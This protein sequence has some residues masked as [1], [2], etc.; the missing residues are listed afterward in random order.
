MGGAKNIGAVGNISTGN[1]EID[2]KLGGGIPGGSLTL[3]EGQPDSGKSVLCQQILWGSLSSGHKATILT[4]ENTV[5]SLVKQMNSLNLD[6]SDY[7]LL[8]RLR[9]SPVKAIKAGDDPLAALDNLR[10]A[11]RCE[12]DLVIVDSLTSFLSRTSTEEAIAFFEECKTLSN[13]TRT[14]IGAVHSYAF[15]ESVLVRISSMCDAHLR[16]RLETMGT[17]LI[18]LLEVAKV[19]G[20]ERSTGNIISFEVEPKWGMRIIPYSKAR[21]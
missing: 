19:R 14:I 13:G 6:I 16:L 10:E 9:I 2:K 1:T 5:K 3:V 21:A 15:A 20:A 8:G 7:Y 4:T 11:I 18:K 12:E 17:Q